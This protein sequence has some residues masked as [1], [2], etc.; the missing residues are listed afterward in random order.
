MTEPNS[1]A[2]PADDRWKPDGTAEPQE[3]PGLTNRELFTLFAMHALLSNPNGHGIASATYQ[4]AV[5][6]ADFQ[7][8]ELN[9]SEK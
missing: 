4:D 8:E 7:I 3:F 5:F 2:F 6:A 1:P 9:R